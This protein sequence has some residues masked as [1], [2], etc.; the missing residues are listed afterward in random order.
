MIRQLQIYF[1]YFCLMVD[2]YMIVDVD[3]W[4]KGGDDQ[5]IEIVFVEMVQFDL[6]GVKIC[7]K[8]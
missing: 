7:I 1:I 2:V 3:Y 5:G 8:F 6:I 4:W